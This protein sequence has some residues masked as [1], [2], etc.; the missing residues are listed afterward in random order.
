MALTDQTVRKSGRCAKKRVP[1]S[2]DSKNH[3]MGFQ[4]TVDYEKKILVRNQNKVKQLAIFAKF[5]LIF[6]NF[7]LIFEHFYT[8]LLLF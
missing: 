1:F 6:P 2:V 5:P 7:L 8:K 4:R 3:K